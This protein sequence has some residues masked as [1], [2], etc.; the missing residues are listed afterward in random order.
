MSNNGMLSN[1]NRRPTHPGEFLREDLLP[2]TGLTKQEF[3]DCL[4]VSRRAINEI[5]NERRPVTID[6]ALRLAR[7]FDTTPDVWVNMQAAVD[8]WET[9]QA[10]KQTYEKIKPLKVA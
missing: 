5:L 7:V 3:A 1:R 2:A 4:G 8:L 9:S 10:N 6:M